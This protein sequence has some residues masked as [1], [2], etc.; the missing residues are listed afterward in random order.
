MIKSV[1]VCVCVC[2]CAHAC[3]HSS[4]MGENADILE[5]KKSLLFFVVF[6]ILNF[7][8]VGPH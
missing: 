4:M 5:N 2:V 7:Q 6:L 1:C 3:A 8:V